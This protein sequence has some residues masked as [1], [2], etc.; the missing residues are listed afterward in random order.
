M[1][2]VRQPNFRTGCGIT[3]MAMLK[4]SDYESAKVWALDTIVCDS[5]LLVNLEQMRKAI[6]LIYGI[7]KVKY[8]H[9]N[10]DGFDK[11]QNYV[12]HGRWSDAKFGCRHWIVYFQGKYYDPVNG[13]LSEIPDDFHITQVF[14]IP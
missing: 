8:Q 6:K 14:P 3:V 12:C 10:T 5:N 7:A 13:V 9:T 4:N 1:K 2:Y 11:S